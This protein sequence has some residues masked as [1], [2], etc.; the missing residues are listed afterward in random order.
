MMDFFIRFVVVCMTLSLGACAHSK[1]EVVS[2]NEAARLDRGL[3][4]E[5]VIFEPGTKEGAVVPDLSSPRLRAILVPEHI[6]NGRLVEKHREWQLEGDVLILGTPA[7]KDG[8]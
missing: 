1:Q 8:K 7:P 5:S 4:K 3:V 6:E 2:E